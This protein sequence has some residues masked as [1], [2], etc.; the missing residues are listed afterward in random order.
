MI[1][2]SRASKN[3]INITLNKGVGP[4]QSILKWI[5]ILGVYLH[6]RVGTWVSLAWHEH[7]HS[8]GTF[9]L[10]CPPSCCLRCRA[11]LGSYLSVAPNLSPVHTKTPFT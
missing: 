3:T 4:L 8:K 9:V 1:T 6:Y 7:S 5:H 10:L 2:S 11:N